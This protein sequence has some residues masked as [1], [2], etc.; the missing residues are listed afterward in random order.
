MHTALTLHH[1]AFSEEIVASI[2]R[3]KEL[4][5]YL[6]DGGSTFLR[7]VRVAYTYYI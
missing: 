1:P 4:E 7:N 6:E 3:A 5:L 2:F